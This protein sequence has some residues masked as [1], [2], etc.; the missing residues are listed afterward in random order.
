MTRTRN[1]RTTLAARVLES[2]IGSLYVAASDAGLAV[3]AFVDRMHSRPPAAPAGSARARGIVD[4]TERQLREYFAGSRRVFDVPLAPE[5]TEFQ[6]AV[7]DALVRVPYG[8]TTS[9][10][11]LARR[12]GRPRAVRAVG[13]ANGANPIAVIVPCHRVIG[14]D[15]SLTGYGGGLDRKRSLLALE[16][17]RLPGL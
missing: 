15:G 11:E 13:A 4:E 10:G 5:G 17:A 16:G 2:P 9:Y 14:A 3:L 8:A 12:A 6:R 7:W 1:D